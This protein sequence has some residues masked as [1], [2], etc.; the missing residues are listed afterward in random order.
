MSRVQTMVHQHISCLMSSISWV[1]ISWFLLHLMSSYFMI[2][3]T[4][5]SSIS[6][7][8]IFIVPFHGSYYIDEFHFM[9]SYFHCSFSWFLLHVIPFHVCFPMCSQERPGFNPP[10]AGWKCL[11]D[12]TDVQIES[13]ENKKCMV[14]GVQGVVAIVP[15]RRAWC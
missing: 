7:V 12:P 13:E 10:T 1:P 14:L 3:I 2:P 8:P 5:M 6:W 15:M 9:S 11:H 4:L